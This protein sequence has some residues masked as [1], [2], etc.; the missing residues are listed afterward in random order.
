MIFTWNDESTERLRTLHETGVSF[1]KIALVLGTT[2]NAI[3][4]KVTRLKLP[5]RHDYV[6]RPKPEPDP[7]KKKTPP[8]PVLP[9]RSPSPGHYPTIVE[10]SSIFQC[11]FPVGHRDGQHVFCGQPTGEE[12]TWCPTHKKIVFRV[13][14]LRPL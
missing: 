5:R 12:P 10:L 14:E 4:G 1:S 2:K 8:K 9:K 11:R 7:F 3:S 6:N 13:V